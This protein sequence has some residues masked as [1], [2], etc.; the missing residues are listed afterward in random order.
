MPWWKLNDD[1][2]RSS[3]TRSLGTVMKVAERP[4]K[5]RTG[6]HHFVSE[7]FVDFRQR[8]QADA[9]GTTCYAIEKERETLGIGPARLGLR[10]GA[11]DET[12]PSF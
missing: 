3:R 12:K 1:K 2:R 10:G 5:T 6:F 9:E 4:K 7:P 8:V 11:S